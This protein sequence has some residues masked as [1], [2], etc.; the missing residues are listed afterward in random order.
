MMQTVWSDFKSF[1][2][3][4]QGNKEPADSV[5]NAARSFRELFEQTNEYQN[6][7]K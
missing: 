1:Y 7:T 6:K 3:I 5:N 4:Y 2:D